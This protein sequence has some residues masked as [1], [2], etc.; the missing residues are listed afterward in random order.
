MLVAP[1]SSL[2]MTRRRQWARLMSLRTL[3]CRRSA[4]G[5]VDGH[6]PSQ[7][8]R[9]TTSTHQLTRSWRHLYKL[10]RPMTHSSRL[11]WVR[12][13]LVVAVETP[14]SRQLSP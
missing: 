9:K 12:L 3:W 6:C 4:E 11:R 13:L 1:T 2:W 14:S 5:P 7:T 8:T 10:D